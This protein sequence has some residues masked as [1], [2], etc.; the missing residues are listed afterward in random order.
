MDSA[1]KK[2]LLLSIIGVVAA[3]AIVWQVV[4]AVPRARAAKIDS[5]VITF[6]DPKTRRAEIEFIHPRSG[7]VTTIS[8][9]LAPNGV[10]TINGQAA[11]VDDLRVGDRASV[12]GM[13]HPDATVVAEWVRVTRPEGAS[14]TQPASAPLESELSLL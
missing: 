12:G 9:T 5:A 8:G 10:V 2:I 13:F 3:G 6:I 1:G 14:S 4:R 7:R 11:T